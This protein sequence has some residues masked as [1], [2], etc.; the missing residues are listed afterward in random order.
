M[1]RVNK[2]KSNAVPVRSHGENSEIKCS[3]AA[4][5][6]RNELL[7]FNSGTK[8]ELRRIAAETSVETVEHRGLNFIKRPFSPLAPKVFAEWGSFRIT[9]IIFR[10][11]V[12]RTRTYKRHVEELLYGEKNI[13][14]NESFSLISFYFYISLTIFSFQQRH[15]ISFRY[16]YRASTILAERSRR[17]IALI[18]F[19][20]RVLTR[21]SF[22]VCARA[23][24]KVMVSVSPVIRL[25][26]RNGSIVRVTKLENAPRFV[27][28]LRFDPLRIRSS[29][30]LV[31]FTTL[32]AQDG[33]VEF[34]RRAKK[35]TNYVRAGEED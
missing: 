3:P 25:I 26:R 20:T 4:S 16:P 5:R 8:H 35:P 23:K 32:I 1:I 22:Q 13:P 18:H 27:P 17:P 30:D 31:P 14:E 28:C 15:R 34:V 10:L 29:L 6:I 21:A 7:F 24:P 11:Y 12:I 33:V 2:D 19:T 9:V